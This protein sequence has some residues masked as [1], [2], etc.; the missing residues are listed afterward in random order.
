MTDKEMYSLLLFDRGCNMSVHYLYKTCKSPCEFICI[1]I[2]N[3]SEFYR[4][5]SSFHVRVSIFNSTRGLYVNKLIY[6]NERT[7]FNVS[8]FSEVVFLPPRFNKASLLL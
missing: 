6:E 1:Y 5:L 7:L 3:L 4:N 8:V 2:Y